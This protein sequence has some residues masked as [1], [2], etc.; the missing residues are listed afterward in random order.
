MVIISRIKFAH[1][2]ILSWEKRR[3][4][5]TIQDVIDNLQNEQARLVA[6][7]FSNGYKFAL[8]KFYKELSACGYDIDIQVPP[9]SECVVDMSDIEKVYKNLK[10]KDVKEFNDCEQS[11]LQSAT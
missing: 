7:G 10:V 4:K 6:I 9:Y 3:R 1:K 2:C 8:E 5:M 11:Y